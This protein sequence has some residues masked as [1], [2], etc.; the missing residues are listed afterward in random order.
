MDSLVKFWIGR[1]KFY[2]LTLLGTAVLACS[3]L[4]L[5][6][7]PFQVEQARSADSLVDSVGVAV[8]L[9]YGDTAY[10]KY[11]EI[12][13]PRLKELG[14]CHIRDGVSLKDTKTLAKFK[15]LAAI[16]IKS[17]VVMDPR[18]ISSPA[19]AVEIAKALASSIEAV[20]GPNEWDLHPNLEYQ[21]QS[22]PEGVRK[23]QAELYSAIKNDPA[24]AHLDVL[25]PSMGRPENASKLGKVACDLGNMHS[26]AGGRM[27]SWRLDDR[28]LPK[29]KIICPSDSIVASECGYHNALYSKKTGHQPGLSEKAAAKYLPRLF[30]EYFNRGIKR[31]YS[32]EL[33][34]LKP[35]PEGNSPK[36]HYGLLRYD[37]TPKPDFIAVK[38][39][40]ALLEDSK[41]VTRN[42]QPFPLKSLEYKLKGNKT[43]VHHTLLQKQNGTFYLILWQ[44]V[45]SFDQQE[46]KDIL[47]P[48]QPLK[49]VLKTAIARAVIYQPLYSIDPIEQSQNP[50]QLEVKVPD[51]LMVIELVPADKL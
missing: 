9:N 32:Y 6:S 18:R 40:L 47:V 27:P 22:F 37:G 36:F 28:W 26:Y 34:D 25:S 49:L 4:L 11:N 12:I 8:H 3:P 19:Q 35:N 42:S 16:G 29:A 38:N 1:Y 15:D 5:R 2:V 31:A 30:F 33:I 46:K 20:E 48:A 24:T 10:G 41:G 7:E 44:E 43:N 13:K 21:G 23:F 39:T 51:H 50:K 14:I 45:S 17:T